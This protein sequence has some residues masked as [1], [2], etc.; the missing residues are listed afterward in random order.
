MKKLKK[1]TH[2]QMLE[3]ERRRLRT[4]VGVVS[5]LEL[6]TRRKYSLPKALAFSRA[7]LMMAPGLTCAP[8]HIHTGQQ[9]RM[10]LLK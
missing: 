1:K 5:F 4:T 10:T 7:G 6:I 3:N 8:E 9:I 2:T